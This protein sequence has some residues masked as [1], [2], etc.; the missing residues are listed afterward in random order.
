MAS[1]VADLTNSS[2]ATITTSL[3]GIRSSFDFKSH[4]SKSQALIQQEHHQPRSPPPQSTTTRTPFY[5]MLSSSSNSLSSRSASLLNSGK[6]TKPSST[7]SIAPVMTESSGG[8]NDLA[9]TRSRPGTPTC[10]QR[11]P[12]TSS[13]RRLHRVKSDK[14]AAAAAWSSS[15]SLAFPLL[16]SPDTTRSHHSQ[17]QDHYFTGVFEDLR[18]RT[19]N[20]RKAVFSTAPEVELLA[21][22]KAVRRL[23]A[24]PAVTTATATKMTT[25]D[26]GSI[27]EVPSKGL[28]RFRPRSGSVRGLPLQVNSQSSRPP[29]SSPATN[30]SSVAA[31]AATASTISSSSVSQSSGTLSAIKR[32]VSDWSG[33]HKR[34]STGPGQ[35][36]DRLTLGQQK[37]VEMEG[38]RLVGQ[39][40]QVKRDSFPS[41]AP[42][43]T[44]A[45][46]LP[47]AMIEASL[48]G[49]GGPG[50]FGGPGPGPGGP[51]GMGGEVG[52]KKKSNRRRMSD[53]TMMTISSTR[54]ASANPQRFQIQR[55][56]Q[57]QQQHMYSSG[58]GSGY[59]FQPDRQQRTKSS[60][61]GISKRQSVYMP[62]DDPKKPHPLGN[63]IEGGVDSR[64]HGRLALDGDDYDDCSS[65]D[66]TYYDKDEQDPL[67]CKQDEV[68]AGVVGVVGLVPADRDP[69]SSSTGLSEKKKPAVDKYGFI[70]EDNPDGSSKGYQE[71]PMS[72]A[73]SSK[74]REHYRTS[75]NK[76]IQAVAQLQPEEVKK[77]GKY[78]KLTRGGI[79]GSVR[80]RVWQFLAKSHQ[81]REPGVFQEL[82]TR[83][84]IPIH[85]V[86]AR[87]IER[88][89]PDHI[90]FHKGLGTG[91]EDL[92]AI[93]N[94][95]AHY[96]PNVEYCQGMGRLV[97]MMLMQM[98]VEEAFWLL[99]AT[100]KGYMSDYFT[101]SLL[102]V[103]I[104]ARVFEK[105]LQD[106]DPKLAQ[107]L[108]RNDVTPDMFIPKW[109]LVLFTMSLPWASVLRVWDVFYFD[110]VKTL[111]RVG[112]A[113][114]QICRQHLLDHCPS[115]SEI[116]DYLLYVPLETLGPEALLEKVTYRIKLSREHIERM[117]AL[118]VEEMSVRESGNSGVSG[119][120]L[121]AK[122]I[123]KNMGEEEDEHEKEKEEVK[124][125]TGEPRTRATSFKKVQAMGRAASATK[126]KTTTTLSESQAPVFHSV[127][128]RLIAT[129]NRGRKTDLDSLFDIPTYTTIK[130]GGPFVFVVSHVRLLGDVCAQDEE[131]SWND[132]SIDRDSPPSA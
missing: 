122:E 33:T 96:N 68:V 121:Q 40:V 91:Q 67:Q 107:H 56:Q 35:H 120:E 102:Q 52:K 126:T 26:T 118:A 101:P 46:L 13:Y 49:P 10:V 39:N 69:P 2:S 25:T 64:P 80:G 82:L 63:G 108:R 31:T 47:K 129:G 16:D 119:V 90:H 22:P 7:Q 73:A 41:L 15:S 30:G 117:N 37:V 48:R 21:D 123:K 127:D 1:S 54:S 109:F 34:S 74:Q 130:Y 6:S 124:I 18:S 42:L 106:H 53:A 75:E 92:H 114:L 132:E 45:P 99:V 71:P 78:K 93:L 112:L 79:P 70:L 115:N 86:I 89:Y 44:L 66:E 12:S 28:G 76:W 105:L 87:D 27:K 32:H 85:D 95:Y 4:F 9:R 81:Y 11:Q 72:A 20:F 98:P 116:L 29:N 104:D 59:P 110:G 17:N 5:Q 97:G 65:S 61:F 43:P 8:S 60:W 113:V 19:H 100:I 58:I 84:H 103:R 94:A 50:G 62:E 83:G 24:P 57:Q 55:Q 3:L 88:C 23:P 125:G 111:F 131:E 51:E 128:S 36:S 38:S 14:D 77:S